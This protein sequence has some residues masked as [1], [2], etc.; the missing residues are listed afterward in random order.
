MRFVDTSF[1]VA[2]FVPRDRHHAEAT[3]IWYDGPGLLLCGNHVA[4]DTWTFLRRRA[5][6]K[7]AVS[8]LN[9][10][11]RSSKVAL[12]HVDQDV[13]AE[14]RLWLHRHNERSCSFVDAVSLGQRRTSSRELGQMEGRAQS[15]PQE[16]Q[17]PRQRLGGIA[18][19]IKSL[20]L[21]SV[22]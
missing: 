17:S 9:A 11:E 1:W 16:C 13:E 7:A 5:E 22:D 12:I 2:L 8:F 4:G 19:E 21:P 3:A 14:A 10:L 20:E 6:H 15:R 18:L